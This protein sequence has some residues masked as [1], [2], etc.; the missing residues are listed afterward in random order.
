MTFGRWCCSAVLLGLLLPGF[1]AAAAQE[2]PNGAGSSPER[3]LPE[4]AT[5]LR[6]V[7][8]HQMAADAILRDYIYTTTMTEVKLDSHGNPKKTETVEADTFYIDGLR[9]E[10][11]IRRD[12]RELTPDE[13]RREAERVDREIARAKARRDK[14]ETDENG[15]RYTVTLAR[16]LELGSFSNERRVTLHGRSTIALDYTGDPR[17]K[18]GNPLETAIHEIAGTVWLDEEDRALSRVDGHFVNNFKIGGGLVASIAKGTSFT[19]DTARVNGEVWLPATFFAQGSARALLVFSIDGRVSGTATNY[20]RFKATSRI[21]P[22]VNVVDAPDV[23]PG[24]TEQP[25][26]AHTP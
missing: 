10:R 5:L 15:R 21:M 6:E 3:P 20:R 7:E 14:G 25:A 13:Q 22:E 19:A 12:G 17:A 26:G 11:V 24:R 2:T 16:M 23:T 8:T 9:V 4:I 18:T 1:P